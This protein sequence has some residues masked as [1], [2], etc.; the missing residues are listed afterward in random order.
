MTQII[1]ICRIYAFARVI[2]VSYLAIRIYANEDIRQQRRKEIPN[3]LR[4]LFPANRKLT[5]VIFI[6]RNYYTNYIIYPYK[7][8]HSFYFI[9]I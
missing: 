8:V 2:F 3:S 1:L 9:R 6:A 4:K 7:R 5:R